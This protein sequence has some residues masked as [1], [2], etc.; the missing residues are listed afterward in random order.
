M[1]R[2]T[3]SPA[4]RY[5]GQM[6]AG[7]E[8]EK[9]IRK[10]IE[11][12]R[13]DV[14]HAVRAGGLR[15]CRATALDPLNRGRGWVVQ[16]CFRPLSPFPCVA[17]SKGMPSRVPC[18]CAAPRKQTETSFL[19]PPYNHAVLPADGS[20]KVNPVHMLGLCRGGGG[21]SRGPVPWSTSR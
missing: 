8:A 19:L 3:P 10:G 4:R 15:C 5:L 21:R 20:R 7:A 14:T 6:L 16:G 9:A 12:L 13:Q 1:T 17:V 11:I 2:G 18:L